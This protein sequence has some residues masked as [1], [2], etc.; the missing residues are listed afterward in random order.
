MA[1]STNQTIKRMSEIIPVEEQKPTFQKPDEFQGIDLMLMDYE[2]AKG[3]YG[4]YYILHCDVVETGERVQINTG[5]MAVKRSIEKLRGKRDLPV[6]FSFQLDGKTW[7][8]V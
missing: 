8:M 3:N 2:L 7:L 6:L 5:S 4:E 1:K